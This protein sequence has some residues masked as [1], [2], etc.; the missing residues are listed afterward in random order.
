MK[1]TTFFDV[2]K[3][4]C[5]IYKIDSMNDYSLTDYLEAIITNEHQCIDEYLRSYSVFNN[6]FNFVLI[7]LK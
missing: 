6:C 7:I 4:M 1:S 3:L 5:K 2:K